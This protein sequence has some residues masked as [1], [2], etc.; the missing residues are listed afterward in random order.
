MTKQVSVI[1]GGHGGMGKAIARELGKSSLLVLAAR[2]EKKLLET[3]AELEEYG[4]EI[5]ISRWISGTSPRSRSLPTL[6]RLW[7]M[8]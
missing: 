8:W 5:R 6:Q 3:Q 4:C 1:T 7:A 2:N